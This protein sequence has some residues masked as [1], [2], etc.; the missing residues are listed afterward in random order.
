MREQDRSS[1]PRDLRD[2]WQ[3][4][5]HVFAWALRRWGPFDL[6]LAATADNARADRYFTREQDA[7]RQ[8]WRAHG[9]R[10]WCNPPYSN[11]RPWLQRAAHEHANGFASCWLIP[12]FRGDVYHAELTYHAATEIVLISPRIAFVLPGVG[13][14]A[15]NTGGSMFVY[16]DGAPRAAPVPALITIA[17]IK[18]GSDAA[19]SHDHQ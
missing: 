15:G 18:R 4:P 12:A 14:K 7:L 16:F 19:N 3:T 17:T 5:D 8:D 13:A 11:V 2:E 1:T 6:D 10:A 9:L